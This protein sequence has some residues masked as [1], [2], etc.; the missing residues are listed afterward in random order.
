MRNLFKEL[1]LP[2]QATPTIASNS[3]VSVSVL[4]NL[5]LHARMKHVEIDPHIAWDKKMAGDLLVNKV[6]STESSDIMTKPLPKQLFLDLR[7][8][9]PLTNIHGP[10]R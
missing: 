1:N 8:H 9:L 4:K 5:I 6:I 10:M 7:H 3:S 2:T